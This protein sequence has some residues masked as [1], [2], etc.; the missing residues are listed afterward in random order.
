MAKKRTRCSITVLT[1]LCVLAAAFAYTVAWGCP[2]APV[3]VPRIGVGGQ[4]VQVAYLGFDRNQGYRWVNFH[5]CCSYDPDGGEICQFE[6]TYQNN[7]WSDLSCFW[8]RFDAPGLFSEIKLFVTDDEDQTGMDMCHLVL[9]EACLNV[10]FGDQ[11]MEDPD[12]YEDGAFLLL[13]DLLPLSVWTDPPPFWVE[14]GSLTLE[15]VSGATKIKVWESLG[16]TT[17]LTL[18]KTWA[19]EDVSGQTYYIEGVALS[20]SLRDVELKLTY[21]CGSESSVDRVRLTVLK[22]EF[23]A[24][25]G[26]VNYGFDPRE[27]L[28]T[29]GPYPWASVDKDGSSDVP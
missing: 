17:E 13:N 10:Y 18:P 27:A 4:Q 28:W 11:W 6:W 20:D 8:R 1:L 5:G 23:Q 7:L 12:E 21:A 14:S 9:V 26:K 19:M 24:R 15:I 25:D 29:G 16:K 2:E 3:S 22:V